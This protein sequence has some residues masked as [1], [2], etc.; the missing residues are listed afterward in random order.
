GAAAVARHAVQ[1][2]VAPLLAGRT[3]GGVSVRL[4]RKAGSVRARSRGRRNVVAH[5]EKRRNASAIAEAFRRFSI[6]ATTLR[7]PRERAR[8]LPAFRRS[9][10]DTPPSVRPARSG[11]TS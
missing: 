3:L 4:L 6:C 7:R 8:T 2:D 5:I 9:R 11:A 10:T 1:R